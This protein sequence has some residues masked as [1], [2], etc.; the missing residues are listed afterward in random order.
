MFAR[1]FPKKFA[2][3]LF[4]TSSCIFSP[5]LSSI[6]SSHPS[7]SLFPYTFLNFGKLIK[8]FPCRN[9]L[10]NW[11]TTTNIKPLSSLSGGSRFSA[12]L[13]H[14]IFE[15]SRKNFFLQ[16]EPPG[17]QFASPFSYLYFLF[18]LYIIFIINV[19]HTKRS[20]MMAI[21]FFSKRTKMKWK[22]WDTK[23]G[24][25]LRGGKLMFSTHLVYGRKIRMLAFSKLNIYGR[26]C[27]Y[28]L[29]E[30]NTEG[31][32]NYRQLVVKYSPR[33]DGKLLFILRRRRHLAQAVIV[34]VAAVAALRLRGFAGFISSSNR[35]STRSTNWLR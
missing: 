2:L 35:S 33:F 22:R 32:E 16:L 13:S 24:G 20:R 9:K 8:H 28:L 12:L 14:T 30:W 3:P 34:M 4:F 17:A 27:V 29:G 11:L 10:P 15:S 6:F 23:E 26:L 31:S 21:I 18:S 7:H 5:P 1:I 25:I 19:L